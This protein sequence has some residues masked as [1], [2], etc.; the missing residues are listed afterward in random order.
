MGTYASPY[1]DPVKA[2]EYYMQHRQLKGRKKRASTSDFNE[3]GRIA[4][5]IVKTGLADERKKA[6]DAHKASTNSA[7]KKLREQSSVQIKALTS[8]VKSVRS[9]YKE[10]NTK[11]R[12]E[13][14]AAINALRDQLRG[15]SKE[16]KRA[17]RAAI[18]ARINEIRQNQ[19]ARIAENK[20]K[21]DKEVEKLKAENQVAKDK[22]RAALKSQVE[23]LRAAHKTKASQLKTQYEDRYLDELDK[24]RTD[25]SFLKRLK[26]RR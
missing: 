7:I 22:I 8:K 25:N 18:Q 6:V 23:K 15:M 24:M 19:K 20:A 1:Y 16:Q 11:I 5:S 2:H 9:S 21:L 4:A 12:N 10:S 13:S 3:R 26:R 14:K 17:N